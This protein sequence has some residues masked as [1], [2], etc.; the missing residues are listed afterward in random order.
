MKRL[1]TIVI[2]IVLLAA[3]AAVAHLHVAA[4]SYYP[5]VRIAAPE[6]LSYLAV[7]DPQR[8]RQGCGVANDRF[9]KPFK[10]LCEKCRIVHA[11]CERK[12]EELEAKIYDGKPVSY[13][14]VAARGFRMAI[15]G[16][17]DAA[18]KTCEL[19]AAD[20]LRRGIKTATCFRANATPPFR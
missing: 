15:V 7:M 6:G 10:T 8:E 12:L 14:Q 18:L 16:E 19:I 1:L 3:A 17:A 20:L 5:V 4:Q 9:L 2:A 13:P 11:R